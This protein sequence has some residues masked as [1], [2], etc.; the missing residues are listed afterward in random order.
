VSLQERGLNMHGDAPRITTDDNLWKTR[1]ARK[2]SVRQWENVF[3][4]TL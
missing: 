3:Q 1:E 2:I 4:E